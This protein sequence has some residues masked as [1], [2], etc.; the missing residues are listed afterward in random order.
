MLMLALARFLCYYYSH[1]LLD[2][3]SDPVVFFSSSYSLSMPQTSERDKA[4]DFDDH[5]YTHI[6]ASFLS[7][8]HLSITL[9]LF[10]CSRAPFT[11]L[12]RQQQQQQQREPNSSTTL[13][14]AGLKLA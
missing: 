11:F 1:L 2:G 8:V 7:S 13:I 14:A 9:S 3:M 6:I 12:E 4:R 10:E 5:D